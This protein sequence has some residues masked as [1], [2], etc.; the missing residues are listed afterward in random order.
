MEYKEILEQIDEDEI[1]SLTQQLVRLQTFNPPG[2]ELELTRFCAAYLENAGLKP[3]IYEFNTT[4]A[5]LVCQISGSAEMAGLVMC[6][7][8]DTVPIGDEAW[9][10]DPFG[11]EIVANGVY[12]RGAT[13]MK[14][15][16]AAMLVTMRTIHQAGVSLRGDLT[17]ALTA[18]EEVDTCGA[19]MMVRRELLKGAG[20]LIVGEPTGLEV[21]IAEKGAIWFEAITRGRA[22][23]GSTPHYGK[24]AI[25]PMI[26][27]ANLLPESEFLDDSHQILGKPSINIGTISGGF[28]TNIVADRCN[29]TI[30]IR[31]IP[32]QE[33]EAIKSGLLAV[34]EEIGKENGVVCDLLVI[35]DRP[36]ID[37]DPED[38]FVRTFLESAVSITGEKPEVC[39]S[40]YFTDGAVLVPSLDVPFVICG[41]GDPSRAHQVDEWVSIDH[42]VKA[43]RIYTLAACRILG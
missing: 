17:L 14:G 21:S 3:R 33:H 27:F 36:A 7:H 30:D 24:N 43:A 42:L 1:V 23:H 18:G 28:K 4:R 2:D 31:T 16:V 15:A 40:T 34:F 29:M 12:G 38:R 19:N 9:R 37:T 22:A 32:G 13:D 11:G 6:G 20:A 10:H 8:Q 35:L 25:V 41:P 5:N 26:K 39:G